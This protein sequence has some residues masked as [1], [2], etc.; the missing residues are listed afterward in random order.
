MTGD[1]LNLALRAF[2][3]RQPFRRF[4]IEFV[5]GDRL[6]VSHPDSIERHEGLFLHRDQYRMHRIFP[7]ASVCQLIEMP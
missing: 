6:I 2:T 5:T 3:T 7:P 1:E 4:W